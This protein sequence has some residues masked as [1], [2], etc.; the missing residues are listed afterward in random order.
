MPEETH[1]ILSQA[2]WLDEAKYTIRCGLD[3]TASRGRAI[4]T[5]IALCSHALMRSTDFSGG[6]LSN[7]MD[8]P[9]DSSLLSRD[10]ADSVLER[11]KDCKATACFLVLSAALCQPTS[12]F[13]SFC[14]FVRGFLYHQQMPQAQQIP[15]TFL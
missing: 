13:C 9:F 1:A 7:L 12:Q 3:T 8:I 6:V 10:N 2:R 11:S 15:Q 4:G 5:S 14:G